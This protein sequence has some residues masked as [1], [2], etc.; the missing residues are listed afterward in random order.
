MKIDLIF[1]QLHNSLFLAGKNH[2]EKLYAKDVRLVYETKSDQLYVKYNNQIAIIPS[3]NISSMS[4]LDYTGFEDMFTDVV[5]PKSPQTH[6][7]HATKLDISKAQ[8]S[9]P[10]TTIQN[11]VKRQ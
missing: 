1:A 9:D 3:S 6:I 11:P 10:T 8:V 2:K 7:S 4:P 5:I